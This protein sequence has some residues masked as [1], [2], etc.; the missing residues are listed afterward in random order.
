MG[1]IERG[2]VR[3]GP[4]GWSYEDWKGIVYPPDMPRGFHALTYLA[5]FF[6][7]VEVDS[8]FYRPPNWR[9][10]ASW[11]Q[12][13][14]EN[15]RFMFTMKL[16]QRFTHERGDWPSAVETRQV[17]DGMAPLVEA[18]KLGALLVQFPWSFKR[19]PENRTW[20][21]RI[22]ETFA[23]Y[24]LAVEI[25][26]AS[27]DRPEML[28]GLGQRKVAFCNID[29][30]VFNDSIGPSDHVT[31][32]MAYVRFHGRNYDNWFRDDAKPYERYDYLYTRD[33]LKPWIEKVEKI[34]KLAVEIYVITNNHYRGQA[35]VNAFELAA[36]LGK[37]EF[38]LP[39]HLVAAYPR[40]KDLGRA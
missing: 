18:G 36:G 25:R 22:V 17:V 38:V 37:T 16:W 15:P 23:D 21:A 24:S 35:V 34:R 1:M 2:M 40:L 6:D 4:A 39:S 8:T 10:C 28:D 14:A 12:K 13:T 32:P 27:W 20:L 29:Q 7:T 5:G 26:H 11:L 19:T 30:P 3:I 31:A 9:H 33:E